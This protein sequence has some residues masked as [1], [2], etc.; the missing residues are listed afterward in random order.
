MEPCPK[1]FS[2]SLGQHK[3]LLLLSGGQAF[4]RAEAHS[5]VTG[6]ARAKA[7]GHAG[8]SHGSVK[9]LLC[10]GAWVTY[11]SSRP[12]AG[13]A[14]S[15]PLLRLLVDTVPSGGCSG[16]VPYPSDEETC[17]RLFFSF[18]FFGPMSNFKASCRKGRSI[19]GLR[20]SFPLPPGLSV[21]H[22][23]T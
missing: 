11:V 13:A 9:T 14:C 22:G 20:S 10:V 6:L 12:V 4:L 3:R 15:G 18:F 21:C 16:D 2:K 5:F 7:S 1:S 23:A 19:A 8:H 17:R